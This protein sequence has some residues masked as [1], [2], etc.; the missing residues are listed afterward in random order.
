V[1]AEEWCS[2]LKSSC[3]QKHSY[4]IE[5][6]IK[7]YT[8]TKTIYAH[9]FHYVMQNTLPVHYL[10]IYGSSLCLCLLPDFFC[11]ISLVLEALSILQ[12]ALIH[13]LTHQSFS[14]FHF[15]MHSCHLLHISLACICSWCSPPPPPKMPLLLEDEGVT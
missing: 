7:V 2:S 14:S 5:L 4:F 12:H 11:C 15:N 1:S 9:V 8:R 6:L 13:S 3:I 10:T